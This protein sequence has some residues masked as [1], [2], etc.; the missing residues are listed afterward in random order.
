[1]SETRQWAAVYDEQNLLL[2]ETYKYKNSSGNWVTVTGLYT[3]DSAGN[4]QSSN[5]NGNSITYTY[6]MEGICTSKIVDGVAHNYVTQN[7]KWYSRATVIQS[8][9]S[10]TTRTGIRLF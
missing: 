9:S 3:Y 1:M 6:D 5:G 2:Q 7:G 10:S 8:C 4:I